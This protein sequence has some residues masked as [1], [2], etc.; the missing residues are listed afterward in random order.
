VGEFDGRVQFVDPADG[1]VR[2]ALERPHTTY[3][4]VSAR[5]WPGSD[6]LVT[7][8]YRGGTAVWDV[9]TRRVL[10]TIDLPIESTV[11]D[12]SVWVAPDG[13]RGATIRSHEGPVI[14][15]LLTRQVLRRLPPLPPPD[16]EP[17]FGV[18]VQGWTPDGRSILILRQLS[19]TTSDLLVVDATTGAITLRVDTKAAAPTEAVADPMSR[20]IAIGT[21]IG[22]LLILDARDGHALS[23]PLQANDGPLLNVSL[24]PDGRYIS[25]AGQPPRLAVWDTRTFRQVGGPLPL[26]VGA[27]DARARFAPDGRLVVTSGSTLRAFTLNPAQWLARA[28]REA[29]RTLTREEFEDVLPGRAY[30]PACA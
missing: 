28:C 7:T 27:V 30:Q 4:V 17:G 8:D 20:Y 29:G 2:P 16:P 12:P 15:D 13:R 9:A 21:T 5:A 26:D 22:T 3:A 18:A 11:F 25:T 10:G 6:L 1:T 19:A 23:P 24:S 14:L